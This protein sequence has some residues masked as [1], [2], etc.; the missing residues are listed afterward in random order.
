MLFLAYQSPFF[1][2]TKKALPS[3]KRGG[4]SATEIGLKKEGFDQYLQK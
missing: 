3:V 4:L 2:A 1:L